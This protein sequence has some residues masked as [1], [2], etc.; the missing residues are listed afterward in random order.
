[1]G[2]DQ[3]GLIWYGSRR[4]VWCKADVSSVNPLSEQTLGTSALN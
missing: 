2:F 4:K 3:Q 1:M